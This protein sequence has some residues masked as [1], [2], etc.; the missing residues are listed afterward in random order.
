M[1]SSS[2][3]LRAQSVRIVG[4]AVLIFVVGLP[5]LNAHAA[6]EA[7]P[8]D[9]TPAAVKL[10]T[11]SYRVEIT[12]SGPYKAGAKSSVRVALT[13][14]GAFHINPQYPYRFKATPAPEGVT[15]PKP[16]LERGDGQ[17]EEKRAVFDVPFVASRAGKFE[18]GG[19]FHMSV[20]SAGSCIVEKAPLELSISVE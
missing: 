15:Y 4:R 7:C 16:I 1:R 3:S 18:V 6:N 9:A 10:E 11:D 5:A 12:A 14:K 17:F 20:C 8:H 13:T 2:I 19:I